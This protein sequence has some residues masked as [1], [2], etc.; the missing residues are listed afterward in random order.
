MGPNVLN[1]AKTD[2]LDHHNFQ[3]IDSILRQNASDMKTS[4]SFKEKLLLLWDFSLVK[5][6]WWILDFKIDP[7]KIKLTNNFVG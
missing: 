5:T 4:A 7:T 2:K 1:M 3:N 6:W